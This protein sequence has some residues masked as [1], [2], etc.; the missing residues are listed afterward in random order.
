MRRQSST[1]KQCVLRVRQLRR[2][3]EWTQSATAARAGIALSAYCAIERGRSTPALDT[4]LRIAGLFG[5]PVEVV[6]ATV[7]VPA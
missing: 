1:S 2:D 6:F 4:A 7:E 5:E 3:R